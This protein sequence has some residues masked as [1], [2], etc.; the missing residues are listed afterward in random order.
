MRPTRSQGGRPWTH[1]PGPARVSSRFPGPRSTGASTPCRCSPPCRWPT[2]TAVT[3]YAALGFVELAVMPGPGGAVQLGPTCAVPLPGP[4][5]GPRRRSRRRQHHAAVVRPHRCRG[6]AGPR[7]PTSCA[8]SVG[9]RWRDQPPRPGAPS[10]WRCVI[11]TATSWCSRPPRP[12]PPRRGG[13]TSSAPPSSSEPT[14]HAG[15]AI[16]GASGWWWGRGGAGRARPVCRFAHLPGR[17]YVPSHNAAGWSSSV[18]S[19]GS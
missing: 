2:S 16:D 8:S 18:S 17:G 19:P 6:R 1:P 4:P 12:G 9:A 7:L 10:S 14:G 15:R 13:T 11:S 3:W 5:A